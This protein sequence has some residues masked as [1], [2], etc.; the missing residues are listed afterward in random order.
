MTPSERKLIYAAGKI[1][2]ICVQVV[3]SIRFA[4][5]PV[6][7]WFQKLTSN[8]QILP[9]DNSLLLFDQS[10]SHREY[11]GRFWVSS[12]LSM[13]EGVLKKDEK[14][15]MKK[16]DRWSPEAAWYFQCCFAMAFRRNR[17][18]VQLV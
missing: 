5:P 16:R 14:K 2:R 18:H 3:L 4:Y 9:R 12:S 11:P 13:S 15:K 6:K 7:S 8:L 17:R 10:N 1:I